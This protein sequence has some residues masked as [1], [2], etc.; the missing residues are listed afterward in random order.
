MKQQKHPIFYPLLG[1]GAV[2][3]L[4][5]A[6]A[7]YGVHWMRQNLSVENIVSSDFVTEQIVSIAG[8]DKRSLVEM[9][10]TLL[11][12]EEKQTY[13][14]LFLNNT[15]MRPGGGFLGSYGVV[16]VDRGHPHVVVMEGSEVLD[17]K[18]PKDWNPQ[19][20]AILTEQL[21]VDKWYFRD[22]NWSPDF[23]ESTKKTL[24]L[25]RAEGGAKANE[26]DAVI[27][28]TPDV[29]EE[30]L[31]LTGPIT[32]DGLEFDAENVTEKLEYEVEYGYEAKGISF[33]NRKQLIPKFFEAI[34]DE[35]GTDLLTQPEAYLGTV[36]SL[37]EEKHIL[38]AGLTSE[39]QQVA[40]DKNWTGEVPVEHDGDF[41]MWVDA[42]LAALK[43]DHALERDIT[44]RI[45]QR[46]DDMVG[47]VE[48]AYQH[49]G[50]FD[51]RTSRY[52][53]Y[54]RLYVPEGSALLGM[55]LTRDG[56]TAEIPRREIDGGKELGK[57]WFGTFFTIEPQSS[58]TMVIEFSLAQSVKDAM[59]TG[60]Y[61]L[62]VQKQLG[63]GQH[64]LTLDLNFD[65]TLQSA[66]P[67]EEKAHWADATYTFETD[68]SVD[69]TFTIDL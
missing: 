40:T 63:T 60:A 36:E 35:L 17:R 62:L 59:V 67:A 30:V 51:W 31:R 22:S 56:D 45:E 49:N 50:T 54:S 20:P 29:L 55:T 43:T 37:L 16:E 14:L 52:R 42:N 1:V 13:L 7:A 3:M 21:K 64:G 48:V 15:E 24:E 41:I 25:Y 9:L 8:E 28:I 66:V 57:Q 38:V 32:V 4:L 27:A 12:M 39:L 34:V 46:D 11:G 10:P 19:P 69:R 61:D 47:V 2:L 68:L 44:Y 58:A 26:I 5:A 53:T 6:A 65:R 18:T 33:A 23:I